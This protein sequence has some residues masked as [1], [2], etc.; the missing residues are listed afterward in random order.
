MNG[1]GRRIPYVIE[2]LEKSPAL[3][4]Q[5][6]V[7]CA[8][9]RVEPLVHNPRCENYLRV[10]VRVHQLLGKEDGRDV[11]YGLRVLAIHPPYI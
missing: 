6:F 11:G 8:L 3:H 7:E 1:E 4:I 10:R 9:H 5:H 2:E